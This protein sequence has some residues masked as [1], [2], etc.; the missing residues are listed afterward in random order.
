[1]FSII[2]IKNNKIKKTINKKNN[3]SIKKSNLSNLS[4]GYTNF[5][6]R[7]FNCRTGEKTWE[8]HINRNCKVPTHIPIC[9]LKPNKC[10]I[11]FCGKRVKL[12]L[13]LMEIER[14]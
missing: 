12:S 9:N 5:E 13:S 4:N 3:R 1:M 2:Y 7:C 14:Q 8:N 10:L 11:L 6:V